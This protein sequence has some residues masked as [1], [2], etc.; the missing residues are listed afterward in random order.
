MRSLDIT[1]AILLVVGGLN[2]GLVG[3]VNF[4]LVATIF[5]QMSMLSRIV[6]IVVGLSAVYQALQWKAIQRRWGLA[7]AQA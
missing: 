2:W 4:D 5:G 3:L 7:P 6:Y 1:V